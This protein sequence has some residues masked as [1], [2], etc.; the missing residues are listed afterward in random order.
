MRI[1]VTGGNGYVGRC[2]S[3]SLL[4]EHEVCIVDNLRYGGWRFT[5]T[6]MASM[7]CE[8]IDIRQ[9]EP[10]RAIIADFAPEAIIHLAAI[11]FIPECEN[12]PELAVST[13]VLGTS[14]VAAACPAGCRL[15]FASTGAVYRPEATAHR[16]ETSAVEPADVYGWTKL[17]GEQYV[18]YFARQRKFPACIVRL[19]NVIGPGETNP[20]VLPEIVAQLKAG[21]SVLSLGNLEAKRDYI[22]VADVARGFARAASTGQLECGATSVVNLGSQEPYSVAEL[23]DLLREVSSRDFRVEPDT[24][25][26]RP[27]DRPYLSADIAK[28]GQQFQ[29]RPQLSIREALTD[30]WHNPDLPPA[31][32]ERYR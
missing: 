28:I 19:F 18:R 1:L 15:V 6:E 8:T 3:R 4:P 27:S 26:M 30:L 5:A 21:R 29:W 12:D 9:L 32:I 22:H 2:L 24:A 31:W 25:R 10:L 20:H 11:H 13:N 16:E 17:H 14:N 23:L 7:R